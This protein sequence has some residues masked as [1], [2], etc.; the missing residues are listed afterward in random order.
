MENFLNR[1]QAAG[2]PFTL[3]HPFSHSF[4]SAT[5]IPDPIQ[6]VSEISNSPIAIDL[7]KSC[8]NIGFYLCF[9]PYKFVPSGD[10]GRFDIVSNIFQKVFKNSNIIRNH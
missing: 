8:F 5:K 10:P 3:F 7:L 4:L 2:Q 9:M 6:K 1:K